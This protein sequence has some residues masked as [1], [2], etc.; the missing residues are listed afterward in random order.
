MFPEG[1]HAKDVPQAYLM[2]TGGSQPLINIGY[3]DQWSNELLRHHGLQP[4]ARVPEV[5]AG[6][7]IPLALGGLLR[8][9]LFTD[10]LP[11]LTS[12]PSMCMVLLFPWSPSPR[13]C[14]TP[15]MLV[16]AVSGGVRLRRH[17]R[18][19]RAL[20]SGPCA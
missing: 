15:T 9:R 17:P 11:R 5:Q 14:P 18:S 10:V 13:W 8:D 1:L 12:C 3:P 4:T 6:P 2:N 16:E 19:S 7:S 20:A